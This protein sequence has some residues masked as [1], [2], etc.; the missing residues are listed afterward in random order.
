MAG[1]GARVSQRATE[2][3]RGGRLQTGTSDKTSPRR[4]QR[5]CRSELAARS[6]RVSVAGD[7]DLLSGGAARD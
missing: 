3:D 1:S 2:G 4:W 5:D 7:N 6:S